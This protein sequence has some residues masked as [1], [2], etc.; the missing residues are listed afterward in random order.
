MKDLSKLERENRQDKL[1]QK[2]KE[3]AREIKVGKFFSC[4][5]SDDFK[6]DCLPELLTFMKEHALSAIDGKSVRFSSKNKQRAEITFWSPA[7][8]ELSELTIGYAGDLEML[9]ITGL[10]REQ[11]RQSLLN[12]VG[13]FNS[14]VDENNINLLVMEVD[15]K[16]D[17]DICDAL[18]GIEY[19]IIGKDSQSWSR[20]DDGL[21]GNTDFSKNVAGVI[22]IKRKPEKCRFSPEEETFVEGFAKEC[23]MTPEQYKERI[24]R[25]TPITDYRLILYMNNSFKHFIEDIKKLLSFDTVVYYNMRPPK[26]EGSFEC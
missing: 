6:D 4:M 7:K 8:I 14:G 13:A 19:E 9:N 16:E 2:I 25:K 21:F 5:M 17:I 20:K 18:F 24:E 26:G 3:K 15:N 1:I 23:N 12:A 22:A 10:A 11:I